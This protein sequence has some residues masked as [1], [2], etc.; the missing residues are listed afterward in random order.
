MFCCKK[1]F[2]EAQPA[3]LE[4]EMAEL[5]SQGWSSPERIFPTSRRPLGL[6]K[7]WLTGEL[8]VAMRL[9][10]WAGVSGDVLEQLRREVR[11]TCSPDGNLVIAQLPTPTL[12]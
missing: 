5:I 2:L 8:F 9:S 12:F 1:S 3:F 10:D 4:E 7:G 6:G 11:Q